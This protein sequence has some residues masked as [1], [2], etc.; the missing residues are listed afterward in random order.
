[1]ALLAPTCLV[2]TTVQRKSGIERDAVV[3]TW[4]YQAPDAAQTAN[5]VAW[6]SIFHNFIANIKDKFGA[7]IS[8]LTNDL[9]AEFWYIPIN[10]KGPLGAPSATVF[11]TWPATN[12]ASPLPSEVS[13]C[14]TLEAHTT[15]IPE[16]AP[17]GTHPAA[18]RRNRKYMGPLDISVV[19]PDPTTYEPEVSS[20]FRSDLTTSYQNEM[21]NGM[22]ASGWLPVCFSR[23]DWTTHPVER[24]WVDNAFDS[25]R[26]RGNDPTL[27]TVI[28]V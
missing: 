10:G 28:Q 18:R 5:F 20:Q 4:H 19:S 14:L 12:L 27:K 17:G 8:P 22:R 23:T 16:N 9:K 7:N 11:G 24:V 13:V 2:V 6:M 21:V 25:Q 26:R 3:N 1:M 15:G